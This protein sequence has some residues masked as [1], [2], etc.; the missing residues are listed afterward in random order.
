MRLRIF[1][2]FWNFQ[3]NWKR[4]AQ[5]GQDCD[6][7]ALPSVLVH[8]SRALLEGA[9][10]EGALQLEETRV[11]ASID[12][13]FET[14][15]KLRGW[16]DSF[17]ARQP[18]YRVF[19][20]ERR[21]VSTIIR[22]KKCEHELSACPSCEEPYRQTVEKGVDTGIVTDLLSLAWEGAYDVA[23][24][25][26]SDSDFVPAV[27]RLQE[28]GMKVINATWRGNGFH[29]SKTCWASLEL[30]NLIGGLNRNRR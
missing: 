8:E 26:S 15:S 22:C 9:G 19:V 20:S 13:A 1:I 2:D 21:P 30:N 18:S 10:L 12:P 14:T 3:L 25:V 16:L 5:A 4:N 17:L 28:K 27:T 7:R 23:L 11:Y 6:W 24:L 29:L